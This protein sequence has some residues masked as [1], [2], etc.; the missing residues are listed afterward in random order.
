MPLKERAYQ[1][2]QTILKIIG[3]GDNKKIKVIWVPFLRTSGVEID[4]DVFY[5]VE[6]YSND[7]KL[8]NNIAR[9][10]RYIQEYAYCNPWDYFATFT[11]DKSKYNRQELKA[12]YSVF[13]K[14]IRNFNQ[15]HKLDIKYL[16]I[17]ELHS[18]NKSWH[19]HGLIYG[20]P[21]EHLHQFK[22]GD[23]M[24]REIAKKVKAGKTI[25]NW[26]AYAKRFGFC[27][28]EPISSHEAISNYIVKY[29]TKDMAKCVTELNAHLYYHSKGLK[30]AEIVKKGFSTMDIDYDY[31]SE[32]CKIKTFDY[33]SE[34]LD[35]LKN[36]FI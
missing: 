5:P 2:D 25:F 31:E 35:T 21:V 28:I 36:T 14:F 6:C 34:L 32:H 18:D 33:S 26:Q 29:I 15:V 7:K 16:L 1:A 12:F 24:S 8:D 30:T 4:D 10:K 27:D 11:I 20:L 23:K 3:H 13:S 19:L 17:P 9:A 22:I